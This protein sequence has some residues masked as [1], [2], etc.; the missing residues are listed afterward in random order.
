MKRKKLTHQ[1]ERYWFHQSSW[2]SPPLDSVNYSQIPTV[3]WM[4]SWGRALKVHEVFYVYLKYHASV[5]QIC[6]KALP[7]IFH[8]ER[9]DSIGLQGCRTTWSLPPR[10][11]RRSLWPNPNTGSCWVLYWSSIAQLC[12]G[13]KKYWHH[14]QGSN[15]FFFWNPTDRANEKASSSNPALSTGER[16]YKYIV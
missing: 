7:C 6:Q 5:G 11:G 8:R 9:W 15:S 1:S 16:T 13:I 4:L 3:E 14:R 12:K 2:L 10:E